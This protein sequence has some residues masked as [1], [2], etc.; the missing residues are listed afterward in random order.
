MRNWQ[1]GP[2]KNFALL[3]FLYIFFKKNEKEKKLKKKN[4]NAAVNSLQSIQLNL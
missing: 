1:N 4:D 2:L 3:S